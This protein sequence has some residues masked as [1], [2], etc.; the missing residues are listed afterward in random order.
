M[1]SL[2]ELSTTGNLSSFSGVFRVTTLS[3]NEE[4]ILESLLNEY[5]GEGSDVTA[6]LQS[7]SMITSEVKAINNQAA[8]LHGER[9]KKA[10]ELLLSYRDGAFTAW[11]VATYGNRQ[12]PYNF[13][14]YYEFYTALPKM[15][16]TKLDEMPRQAVY[17]LASRSGEQEEK[18]EIVKTYN[19]QT[20]QEL[21]A[22]IR[23]KFPLS[24]S[25]KRSR[26]L[27]N[28]AIQSL[29]RLEKVL[30]RGKFYPS[31]EQREEL[32]AHL[33][34]LRD[35]IEGLPYTDRYVHAAMGKKLNTPYR[36]RP[37]KV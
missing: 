9:I 23:E 25:D 17:T 6:D 19:G 24:T 5:K 15:L 36:L 1:T 29:E 27:S 11:L 2:A 3:Q 10:Q 20:K 16:H 12:T 14:Q 7:L 34:S 31:Q 30:I 4:A 26:D 18:E 8:I 37:R 28:H 33:D 22:L 21:L 32:L 13:L 35:L